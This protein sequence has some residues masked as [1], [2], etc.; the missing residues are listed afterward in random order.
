MVYEKKTKL[1]CSKIL[2]KADNF[3]KEGLGL[4]KSKQKDCVSYHGGG[5]YVKLSCCKEKKNN[6]I[7]IETREWDRKVKKFLKII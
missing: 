5:G 6:I 1:D 7:E 4:S 3:Y 2:K